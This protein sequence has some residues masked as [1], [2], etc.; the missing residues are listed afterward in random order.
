MECKYYCEIGRKKKRKRKGKN[1]GY[2]WLLLME[3]VWC[4][5]S[6]FL[7]GLKS[8]I[9][10]EKNSEVVM[11]RDHFRTHNRQFPLLLC[12]R[13]RE[14]FHC[15]WLFDIW[16]WKEYTIFPWKG[17][18]LFSSLSSHSWITLKSHSLV[19]HNLLKVPCEA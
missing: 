7:H 17:W 13:Q 16:L 1:I 14:C 4:R 8:A 18:I 10:R 5:F 12:S 6:P 2:A 9:P 19:I 3:I 15:M 11:K